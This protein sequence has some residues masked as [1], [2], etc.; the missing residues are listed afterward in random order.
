MPLLGA[1]V[2]GHYLRCRYICCNHKY[3][4][5]EDFKSL[6]TMPLLPL[7]ADAPSTASGTLQEQA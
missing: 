3:L 2:W 5:L 6:K 4:K 1:G 7:L